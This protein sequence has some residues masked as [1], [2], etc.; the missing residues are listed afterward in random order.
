MTSSPDDCLYAC[1]EIKTNLGTQTMAVEDIAR[2]EPSSGKKDWLG[3][4]GDI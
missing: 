4:I 3:G 1:F 2:L